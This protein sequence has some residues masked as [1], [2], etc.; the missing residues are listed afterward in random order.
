MENTKTISP[1]K[2]DEA[3]QNRG[4]MAILITVYITTSNSDHQDE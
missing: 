3:K 1:W 4:K 2:K